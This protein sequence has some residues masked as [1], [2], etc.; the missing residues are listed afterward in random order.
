[1][2]KLYL[3]IAK[4]IQGEFHLKSN[5]LLMFLVNCSGC[6]LYALPLFNQL[7]QQYSNQLGFVGVSIAFEDFDLNTKE[8]TKLLVTKGEIISETKKP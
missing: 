5:H 7:Y 3:D 8:N 4:T 2:R 6:F 1:M